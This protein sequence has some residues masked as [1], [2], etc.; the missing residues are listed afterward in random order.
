ME[1]VRFLTDEERVRFLS[2]AESRSYEPDEVILGEGDYNEDIFILI[3]GKARV[4]KQ[5][6]T[7]PKT[8]A[9]IG[10]GEAFGEMSLLDGSPT[11]SSVVAETAVEA[12][13]LPLVA[14]AD[15]LEE[16]PM[17]AS[18]LYHSLA[19]MLARRLRERS[20]GT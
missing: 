17:L 9:Y 2:R 13:V 19:V 6:E 15:L 10:T 7:G 20:S 4:D 8:V 1:A 5:L 11:N 16:D 14:V 3:G 18:H 12:Y